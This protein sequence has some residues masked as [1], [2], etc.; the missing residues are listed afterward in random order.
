M[1][2]RSREAVP[3]LERALAKTPE[4]RPIAV[5]DI[6][7]RAT[8]WLAEARRQTGDE[9]GAQFAAQIARRDLAAQR[10]AGN[11]YAELWLTEAM[12]AAFDND[13]DRVITS[14][15]KAMILGLRDRNFHFNTSSFVRLRDE[16]RFDAVLEELEELIAEESEQVLQLI[17]FNNP[18][19]DEWQPLPETC[20]DVVERPL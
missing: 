13:T 18:A 8:I 20:E 14:L 10:A 15:E 3:L 2:G 7:V 4:G 9:S 1:A 12:L 5:I 11:N 16:P 6:G 19:P 17:C